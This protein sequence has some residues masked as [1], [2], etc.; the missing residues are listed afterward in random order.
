MNADPDFTKQL[1]EIVDAFAER[2]RIWLQHNP[3]GRWAVLEAGAGR[4]LTGSPRHIRQVADDATP[5]R[6]RRFSSLSRARAFARFVGGDVIH[7]RR[8]APSGRRWQ[9]Q[10]PW[11]WVLSSTSWP[12]GP[13][14]SQLFVEEP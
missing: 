6:V 8:T 2:E 13:W 11:A 12:T 7:W 4:Y 1:D 5:R 9:R 14:I 10:S 3:R